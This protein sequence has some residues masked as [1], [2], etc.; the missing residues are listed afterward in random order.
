MI[1]ISLLLACS[2]IVLGEGGPIKYIIA[3]ALVGF[4]LGA[5]IVLHATIDW[6]R[7]KR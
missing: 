5:S 4:C 7:G 1:V 2:P 3:F 6:C